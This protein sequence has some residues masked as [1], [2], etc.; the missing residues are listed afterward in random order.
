MIWK[1][2]KIFLP[3]IAGVVALT[4]M[5]AARLTMAYLID[6]ETAENVITIGNVALKIDEGSYTN[7]SVVA[8]YQKIDKAPK[9]INTG[10]KDEF[11][12]FEVRVPK[13]DVTLLYETDTKI[14][15]T[16]YKARTKIDKTPNERFELFKLLASGTANVSSIRDDA[17]P[18]RV[19]FDY[20]SGSSSTPGWIYLHTKTDTENIEYDK[21]IFGYNKKL[22]AGS[23]TS[24]NQTVTLF[25]ELQLKSFIDEELGDSS[26]VK[27]D[28]TAYGIQSDELGY[29]ADFLDEAALTEIW[30]I[31]GRKQVT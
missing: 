28:V 6:T 10:S 3:I 4:V 22:I 29:P 24:T 15:D 5:I 13:R 31:I 7:S 2:K 23:N 17:E 21:Y 12:F 18:P 9:I 26:N 25:D 30:D 16:V 8:A 11:V 19:V 20:H 27:V 14:D 1:K